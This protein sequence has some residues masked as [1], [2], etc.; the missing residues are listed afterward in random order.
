MVD[1]RPRCAGN[2]L[3]QETK[4]VYDARWPVLPASVTSP[5][6]L[7]TTAGYDSV[8]G[9]V[10]TSTIKNVLGDGRDATTTYKWD[11]RFEHA[12][13]VRG[14]DS[15]T[16][17]MQYDSL[18]LR[19]WQQ[20]GHDSLDDSRRVTFAYDPA[21]H[22]L[23][24]D[25]LPLGQKETF[26]YDTLLLNLEQTK[27]PIGFLSLTFYDALGRDTLTVTP[28]DSAPALARSTLLTNGLRTRKLY[29]DADRVWHSETIGAE[30]TG[31]TLCYNGHTSA[32]T[33][34]VESKFDSAGRVL[35]VKR[36]S[37][38][39]VA[40]VD[41][42]ITTWTYDKLGRKLSEQQGSDVNQVAWVYDAAGN[43]TT[44]FSR[45]DPLKILSTYDLLDRLTQKVIPKVVY[46]LDTATLDGQFYFDYPSYGTNVIPADTLRFTYD[47]GGNLTRAD[48]LWAKIRREYSAAGLLLT[49]KSVMKQWVPSANDHT[50]EI[51]HGYDV[52]GRQIWLKHPG[53]LAS[54]GGGTAGCDS[55]AHTYDA[56][57]GALDSVLDVMGNRYG[58]HYDRDGQL[59]SVSYP[60]GVSLAVTY[61]ADGRAIRR[62][63]ANPQDP[64]AVYPWH[65][66]EVLAYDARGKVVEAVR[67]P[68]VEGGTSTSLRYTAL[69]QLAASHVTVVGNA[70]LDDQ[71]W[72]YD[73]LG[74]TSLNCHNCANGWG[75]LHN[76]YVYQSGTARLLSMAA[77]QLQN[78]SNPDTTRNTFDESGNVNRQQD[79]RYNW[80]SAAV[81]G[82]SPYFLG[83][84]S[85]STNECKTCVE[86][87]W[88]TSGGSGTVSV[89]STDGF[90]YYDADD[91]LRVVQK[92]YALVPSNTSPH[93]LHEE[94]RYDALGRR[95]AVRTRHL[96]CPSHTCHDALTRTVWDGSQILYELRNPGDTNAI[97]SVLEAEGAYPFGWNQ[98]YAPL[99]GRVGYIYGVG[100]VDQP[101]AV[102]RQNNGNFPA[103]GAVPSPLIMVP[104]YNFQGQPDGGT[105]ASGLQS[106][107]N[108]ASNCLFQTDLVWAA[109]AQGTP[110]GQMNPSSPTQW[111]GSATAAMADASGLQYRRN[112]YYDG[113]TGRFTQE[114]PIGVA[115]GLNS[116]GFAAGDPVNY[117]DPLGLDPCQASSAWT[118]CL[119]QAAA[120]WGA[121]Q[122]GTLGA[123]ALNVAAAANVALEASG[124]NAA[125]SAGDALGSGHLAS[126]GAQLAMVFAV[127]GG[128]AGGGAE[129]AIAGKITGFTEHGL[130]QAISRDGVG[131]SSKAILGAVSNPTKVIQQA[132]GKV[133]Y[134]GENATVVLNKAGEVVTT[135]ARNSSGWRI[136]P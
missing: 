62:L 4:V 107:C 31:C 71:Q 66:D 103:G 30:R 17:W 125:A 7:V 57:T 80:G 91:R 50:Y 134:I 97:L 102:V 64:Q 36:K 10:L 92:S 83:W 38:P 88:G 65:R 56:E 41:S 52:A 109:H 26:A 42:V 21:T 77:P 9:L 124:I 129:R 105:F 123:V 20:V 106:L 76:S 120:D 1:Q 37:V 67:W 15:V 18:G 16:T 25:S 95:I 61:D 94:Y 79:L 45:R 60:G 3:G 35:Q 96:F 53:N 55:V 54:C 24:S 43:P 89:R 108:G 90:H 101:I 34:I 112:R 87:L 39:D 48:N 40:H 117:S 111:W 47:A 136:K 121:Q 72:E 6:R 59:D 86:P 115:G 131:V 14:P 2:A 82:G 93:V 70:N 133:K 19:L 22:L 78:N 33:L 5:T 122:G 32:Q 81:S 84:M 69:G 110:Y 130:N 119:A 98:T 132:E 44:K 104:Q 46:P 27:T 99:F 23:V 12:T 29:D 75:V 73:A 116:Y 126:G 28:I 49:D 127:P 8:R 51:Q 135:W 63:G 114:D 113:A 68:N 85:A 128:G 100:G 74:N 13:M 118:E 58:Y 11:P